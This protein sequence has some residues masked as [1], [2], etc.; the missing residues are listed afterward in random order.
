MTTRWSERSIMTSL[1]GFVWHA[2]YWISGSESNM[3]FFPINLSP[4]FTAW[5][6]GQF[7]AWLLLAAL[8]GS[9]SSSPSVCVC[10]STS[11]RDRVTLTGDLKLQRL[12]RHTQ[13]QI[14]TCWWSLVSFLLY[15]ASVHLQEF[16]WNTHISLSGFQVYI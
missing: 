10:S 16:V 6:Q 12:S 3:F 11:R 8:V 13:Y 14:S 15:S 9:S 2:E 4:L 5:S 7:C 1:I